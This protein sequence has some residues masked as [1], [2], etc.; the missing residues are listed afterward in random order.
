MAISQEDS[1]LRVAW[2]D[3]KFITSAGSSFATPCMTGVICRLL[4]KYPQLK[5]F[6]IKTLLYHMAEQLPAG[7]PGAAGRAGG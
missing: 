1:D 4:Q 7:Q 6:E 3:H 5:P 2:L